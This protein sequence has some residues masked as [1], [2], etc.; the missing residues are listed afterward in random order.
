MKRHAAFTMAARTGVKEEAQPGS[1][2]LVIHNFAARSGD[3]LTLAKGDRIELIERDDEF[4]DG[5]FLGKH[6]ANGQTGL[7]PQGSYTRGCADGFT[8]INL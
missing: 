8:R 2:L 3:E 1:T 5:W 6:I 7:F 4:G